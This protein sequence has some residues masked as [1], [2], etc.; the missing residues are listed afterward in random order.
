MEAGPVQSSPV[1]GRPA[2]LTSRHLCET[3]PRRKHLQYSLAQKYVTSRIHLV[4][5]ARLG[6][7][8]LKVRSIS[9]SLWFSG[10]IFTM[11]K[12][13]TEFQTCTAG[14]VVEGGSKTEPP[15]CTFRKFSYVSSKKS[16][17]FQ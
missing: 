1:Q 11:V 8:M 12:R 6:A 10:I 2:V 4:A 14:T 5:T 15:T 3:P 16:E 17:L 9:V 13:G 7:K